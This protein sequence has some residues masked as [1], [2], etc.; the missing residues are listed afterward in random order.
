MTWIVLTNQ[1]NVGTNVYVILIG[2][3]IDALKLIVD[4]SAIIDEVNL[5]LMILIYLTAIFIKEVSMFI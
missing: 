1:I 2:N 3:F 5:F 4:L